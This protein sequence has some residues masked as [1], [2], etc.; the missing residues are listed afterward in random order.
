MILLLYYCRFRCQSVHYTDAESW[1]VLQHDSISQLLQYRGYISA[2]N[3]W[4]P[5]KLPIWFAFISNDQVETLGIGQKWEAFG[6]KLNLFRE[7]I[8]PYKNDSQKIIV[9]V[10]G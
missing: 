4:Y 6:S 10:D 5:A 9:Y 1:R 8:E 2:K 7:A 3:E